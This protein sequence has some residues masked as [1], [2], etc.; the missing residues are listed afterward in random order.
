M[1]ILRFRDLKFKHRKQN[2]KETDLKPQS[3]ISKASFFPHTVDLILFSSKSEFY[4]YVETFQHL[5]Q[6]PTCI[7]SPH[8]SKAKQRCL[9]IPTHSKFLTSL[10]L[11]SNTSFFPRCWPPRCR[12]EPPNQG[13]VSA[14]RNC[15]GHPAEALSLSLST[16]KA[17]S[18]RVPFGDHSLVFPDR[19]ELL[20]VRSLIELLSWKSLSFALKG[21]NYPAPLISHSCL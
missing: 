9:P 10:P 15:W 13:G 6:Q 17:N 11:T 2:K 8:T 21:L 16:P 1:Y 4:V 20:V 12:G 3:V 18:P 14:S 7:P 5:F 19:G